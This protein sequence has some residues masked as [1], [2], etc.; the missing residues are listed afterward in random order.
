V[1]N[2]VIKFHVCSSTYGGCGYISPHAEFL[3]Q[4]KR[5]SSLTRE[6]PKCGSSQS[7]VTVPGPWAEFISKAEKENLKA[8]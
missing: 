1:N 3:S 5:I 8:A 2:G 4:L 6:C 7:W